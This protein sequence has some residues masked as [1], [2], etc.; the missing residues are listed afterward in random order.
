MMSAPPAMPPCSAI[1]P[2]VASHHFDDH[3]SAMTGCSSVQPVECIDYYINRR[4]ES[5]G[6][7][8]GFQIVVDRFRDPDAIDAGFL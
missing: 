4:I 6:R 5:K 2:C 7:R 3:H 1:Q 8:R